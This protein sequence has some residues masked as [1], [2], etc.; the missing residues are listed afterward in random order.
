MPKRVVDVL[1]Y[2][3]VLMLVAALSELREVKRM[4]LPVGIIF[5]GISTG[6]AFVYAYGYCDRKIKLAFLMIITLLTFILEICLVSDVNWTVGKSINM[7]SGCH[8][9][10]TG[11]KRN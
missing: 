8:I 1:G 7:W 11:R 10:K 3:N 6:M 5:A 4:K 9:L 2:L